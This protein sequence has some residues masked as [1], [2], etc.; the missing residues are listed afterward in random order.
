MQTLS[1]RD[2]NISKEEWL[3]AYLQNS[4]S[5]ACFLSQLL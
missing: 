3:L 1:V 5:E 4:L 2:E